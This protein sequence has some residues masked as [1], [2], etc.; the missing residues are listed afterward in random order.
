MADGKDFLYKLRQILNEDGDSS[1]L[2]DK[3]SYSYLWEAAKEFVD[4]TRCLR[5][6]QSITTV[7]AQSGYTLNADFSK[8]YLRDSQKRHVIKYNDGSDNHWPIYKPYEEII[9]EDN[10]TSV[11]I[12]SYFSIIDDP[13]LDS[14]ITGTAS[15]AGAASGG[16]CTLTD[17]S[18]STKF[19]DV[20]AGDVVHNTTDGADG[21]V[22]SKTSGTALV[23]ALFGGSGND[24]ASSDSYVIQPQGRMQ[25]YIN[26]PSSTAAHIITFYYIQSPAPVFSQYGVYR[27]QQAY[28]DAIIKFA[29]FRY[30]YRD[31]E[32]DFGSAWYREFERQIRRM[33]ASL[34]AVYGDNDLYVSFR[35]RT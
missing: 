4:R 30:K 3:T 21:Y 17:T 1:F 12:P 6:S 2:D 20:S 22:I 13:V 5:S 14:Q 32:P 15:A 7:V 23:T 31:S 11:S 18:S 34:Q 8:L 10:T 16:Q 9:V 35:K 29:A 26:P 33:K 27:F 25:L 28:M 19:A 24:W